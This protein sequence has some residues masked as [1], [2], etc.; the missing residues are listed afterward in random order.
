MAG[1]SV[2]AFCFSRFELFGVYAR[3]VGQQKKRRLNLQFP[4]YPDTKKSLSPSLCGCNI[5]II[6]ENLKKILFTSLLS[7]GGA[8]LKLGILNVFTLH[9]FHVGASAIIISVKLGFR[10]N[11]NSCSLSDDEYWDNVNPRTLIYRVTKHF[12]PPCG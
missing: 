2:F 4:Q 8:R 7:K 5:G 3:Q 10:T 11:K 1:E 9:V 12:A 6:L